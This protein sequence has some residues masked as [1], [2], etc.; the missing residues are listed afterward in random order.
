MHVNVVVDSS[1]IKAIDFSEIAAGPEDRGAKNK[2]PLAVAIA[3]YMRTLKT[4]HTSLSPL[5]PLA[6]LFMFSIARYV[7]LGAQ[8]NNKADS[9]P[10]IKNKIK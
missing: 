8:A 6:S 1:E 10:T 3:M 7:P 2:K 4:F 5:L 9:L